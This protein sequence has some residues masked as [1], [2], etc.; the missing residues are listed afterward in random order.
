MNIRSAI[1]VGSI[2]GALFWPLSDLYTADA[3][4]PVCVDPDTSI[5][6]CTWTVEHDGVV[7]LLPQCAEE[8]G[9]VDGQSCVWFDPDTGKGYYVTSDAYRGG[10]TP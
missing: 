3:S 9:N 8:D 2:A 1:L 7:S 4:P 10:D 5:G 6:P